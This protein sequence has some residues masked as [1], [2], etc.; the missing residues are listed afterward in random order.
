MNRLLPRKGNVLR[1]EEIEPIPPPVINK[2]VQTLLIDNH[3]RLLMCV[4][5]RREPRGWVARSTILG[6]QE[7]GSKVIATSF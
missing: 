1:V 2:G 5:I 6:N 7:Q 4:T 3:V